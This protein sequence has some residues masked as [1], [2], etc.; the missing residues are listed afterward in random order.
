LI[1]EHQEVVD[2]ELAK[3]ANKERDKRVKKAAKDKAKAEA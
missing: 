2:A 3:R 1:G